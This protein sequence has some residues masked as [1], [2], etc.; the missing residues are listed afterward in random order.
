MTKEYKTS[1]N[2]HRWRFLIVRYIVNPLLTCS[3]LVF[4]VFIIPGF[5]GKRHS[6]KEE[7]RQ[8]LAKDIDG[9]NYRVVQIGS[10]TWLADNLIV[11]RFR[12]GD[13]IKQ[14]KMTEWNNA[15][16]NKEPAWCYYG[17]LPELGK[18]YGIIY[19]LYAVSDPRGLAPEGWDIPSVEDWVSLIRYL[20]GD[21]IAGTK[22]KE[23]SMSFW[24]IKDPDVM[25]TNESGFSAVPGGQIFSEPIDLGYF[26]YYW[27]SPEGYY[28]ENRDFMVKNILINPYDGKVEIINNS[29]VS[30][31]TVRCIERPSASTQER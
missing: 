14:V 7:Y 20:G 19:N 23:Q 26:A 5:T 29:I 28:K 1:H 9:N 3:L 4:A 15:I 8:S 11:K 17:D 10:Q 31:V 21:S 24:R 12:N 22:L 2:E 18:Q 16:R 13:P 30:G 27:I 25:P 6:S